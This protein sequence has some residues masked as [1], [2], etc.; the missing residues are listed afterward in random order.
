ME[1]YIDKVS[2]FD[3]K[4]LMFKPNEA[5]FGKYNVVF[6]QDKE[7]N[8]LVFKRIIERNSSLKQN[9]SKISVDFGN[10]QPYI[11]HDGRKSFLKMFT[12]FR[13]LE[14]IIKNLG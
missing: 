3:K 10:H 5:A 13:F 8:S 9:Q 12:Q 14:N 4:T 7:L 2:N 11:L 1:N 6:Y